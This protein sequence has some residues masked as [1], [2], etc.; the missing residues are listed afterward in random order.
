[1]PKQRPIH[2]HDLIRLPN[3]TFALFYAGNT[4]AGDQGFL[5]TSED[6]I[7]WE[8]FLGNPVLPLPLKECGEYPKSKCWDGEHRRPRSVFLYQGF[9]HHL[10]VISIP[11]S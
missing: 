4:P 10:C 6:L 5:A 9:W 7:S 2:E 3:G 11:T 8:N 1:M